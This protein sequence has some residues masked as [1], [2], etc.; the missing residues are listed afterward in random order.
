MD[1]QMNV[2]TDRLTGIMMDRQKGGREKERH[3]G[4][5]TNGWTDRWMG[6]QMDGWTD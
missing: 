2:Y 3:M 4:E 5:Q 1:K 6:R